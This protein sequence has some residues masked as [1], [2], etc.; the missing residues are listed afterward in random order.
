VACATESSYRKS[1]RE[2]QIATDVKLSPMSTWRVIQDQG[3]RHRKEHPATY[4]LPPPKIRSFTERP[5]L[6]NPEFLN[7]RCPVLCIEADATYCKNQDKLGLRHEVKLATLYTGKKRLGKS[8]KRFVLERKTLL[9]QRPGEST[10][11]FL[12]RIAWIARVVYGADEQS[13]IVVRGDGDPWIKRIQTDHFSKAK[14][15]LDHWHVA[16][17]MRETFGPDAT[18]EL[19]PWIYARKPE[20]LISEIDRVYLH[21]SVSLFPKQRQAI[22]EFKQYITNNLDGLM[23]SNIPLEIKKRFPGMFLRCSGVIERNI[24]LVIGERCKLKRMSWSRSGLDN[25]VVLREHRIN[26][27][28]RSPLLE[29]SSMA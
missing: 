5:A 16:K 20:Q 7:P 13:A 28:N 29:R 21:P 27:A 26:R 24:D 18:K 25:I 11:A 8:R 23:P 14:Y 22:L 9:T 17:K 12:G 1:T 19:M 6:E 10:D 15:F 4:Q 2:V 3:D